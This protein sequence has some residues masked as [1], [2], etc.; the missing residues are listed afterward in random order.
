MHGYAGFLS[1]YFLTLRRTEAFQKQKT[2]MDSAF[3]FH[4]KFKWNWNASLK[5]DIYTYIRKSQ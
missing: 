5:Q 3:Y 2:T 4:V 1:F